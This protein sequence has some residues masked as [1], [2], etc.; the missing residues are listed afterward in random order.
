MPVNR[1]NIW[2]EFSGAAN[3][4]TLH[5]GGINEG[6]PW[7]RVDVNTKGG[8]TCGYT[9]T[10]FAE[11]YGCVTQKMVWVT[12][13]KKQQHDIDITCSQYEPG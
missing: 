4:L 10:I 8:T 7:Y 3:P 2:V 5:E 6:R 1:A 9:M 12:A 11:M 13:N